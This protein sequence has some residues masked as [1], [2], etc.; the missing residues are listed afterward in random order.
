MKNHTIRIASEQDAEA[1]LAIYAPYVQK[2]AVTFEY[3][4][5]TVDAFAARIRR[6]LKKYP[7]LVAEQDKEL[8]G[9]A[10][11]GAFHERAARGNYRL[12]PHGQAKG[13]CG[14]GTVSG[15]G[16]GSGHAE[17]SEHE[18]LHRLP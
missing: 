3:E 14:K 11:A 1:L 18:C 9:Y 13:R 16:K 10:C 7:Y 4:T 2:T 17:Y 5:P 15:A 6:I 8:I 12:C